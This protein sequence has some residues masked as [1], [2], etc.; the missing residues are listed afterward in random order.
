M[1]LVIRQESFGSVGETNLIFD[2]NLFLEVVFYSFFTFTVN[3]AQ[4]F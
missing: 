2:L 4:L 1:D 3:V